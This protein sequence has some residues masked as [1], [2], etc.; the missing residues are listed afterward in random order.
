MI[1]A[2]T[3]G[4][5]DWSPSLIAKVGSGWTSRISPSQ[6]AAIAAAHIGG[7]SDAIPVPWLGST[8][9]GK[10]VRSCR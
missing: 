9:T 5:I 6:P 10:C 2:K 1:F 7:T 3:A 8:T 4:V